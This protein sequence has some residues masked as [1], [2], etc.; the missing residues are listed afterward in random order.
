MPV[1]HGS[2]KRF[3]L[4][5][6]KAEIGLAGNGAVAPPVAVDGEPVAA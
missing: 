4:R 3:F 5:G 6:S 1:H 2:C